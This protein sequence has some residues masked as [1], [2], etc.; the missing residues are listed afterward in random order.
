MSTSHKLKTVIRPPAEHPVV[1]A[2]GHEEFVM[3]AECLGL[4]DPL[5]ALVW[6]Q[7]GTR[8]SLDCPRAVSSAGVSAPGAIP[9]EVFA[10]L[11]REARMPSAVETE[12]EKTNL[13]IRLGDPSLRAPLDDPRVRPSVQTMLDQT[14]FDVVHSAVAMASAITTALMAMPVATR[15]TLPE[16]RVDRAL[17]CSPQ[18]VDAAHIGAM[19]P[20]S[21]LAAAD[22]TIAGVAVPPVAPTPA[23]GGGG[24]GGGGDG[25]GADGASAPSAPPAQNVRGRG[26][27]TA[28]ASAGA[29]AGAS[30]TGAPAGGGGGRR[31]PPTGAVMV[32]LP[33]AVAFVFRQISTALGLLG[34]AQH[35]PVAAKGWAAAGTTAF[36]AGPDGALVPVGFYWSTLRNAI[37]NDISMRIPSVLRVPSA[38]VD[39]ALS[40]IV[41]PRAMCVHGAAGTVIGWMPRLGFL[42]A[43]RRLPAARA[44][45]ASSW[46]EWHEALLTAAASARKEAKALGVTG[47]KR[48][49]PD[50]D[51]AEPTVP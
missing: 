11:M 41:S 33:A 19:L 48:R 16:I 5:S 7:D 24:G 45:L 49:A 17:G 50:G 46:R 25:A 39:M 28:S 9:V 51:G 36:T 43:A 2:T 47:T 20:M 34:L 29:G 14:A 26:N 15:A 6:R 4:A 21:A 31:P 32:P 10:T 40:P 22:G 37:E 35:S 8:M 23:T 27:T 13:A 42:L 1:L 38:T 12:S 18:D 3:C 44:L 30:G